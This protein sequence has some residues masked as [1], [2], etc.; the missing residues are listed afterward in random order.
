MQGKKSE[1]SMK[2]ERKMGKYSL[3]FGI[4]VPKMLIVSGFR[5]LSRNFER[6]AENVKK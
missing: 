4:P 6:S 1:T 2:I 3:E 5:V